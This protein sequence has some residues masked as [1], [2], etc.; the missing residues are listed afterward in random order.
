[1]NFL[2]MTGASIIT[3]ALIFYSFGVVTE[4]R[5]HLVTNHV[6]IFITLGLICDIVG[7]A[8]MIIGSQRFITIHGLIGYSGLLGMLTD[9]LLLMRTKIK[10]GNT[11]PPTLHRYT[12]MAYIWWL[13]AYFS[14]FI[15]AM[16]R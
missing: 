4:Q 8:C 6:L 2:L 10:K 15:L 12:L 16:M 9:T 13:V 1:M 5:R 7:T 3:M 14:G 11:V